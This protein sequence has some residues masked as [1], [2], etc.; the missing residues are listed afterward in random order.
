M[1]SQQAYNKIME[2]FN[3]NFGAKM[4]LT[5]VDKRPIADTHEGVNYYA[6][7]PYDRKVFISS[8]G[9]SHKGSVYWG[10][11]SKQLRVRYNN[12]LTYIEFYW[13]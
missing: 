5:N 4:G 2:P 12:D 13:K 9:Y 3:A 1:T 8:D 6:I 11:N 10:L 7:P